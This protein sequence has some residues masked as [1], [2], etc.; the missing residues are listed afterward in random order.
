MSI[1]AEFKNRIND[2]INEEVYSHKVKRSELPKFMGVDYSSL[3]NAVEYGII[4]TPRII[5]KMADYFD[6]SIPYLLGKSN[7]EY[8]SKSKSNETFADRTQLLC[9]EKNVTP[10]FVC[11]ECNF[12]PGYLT[13]WIKNGYIP[14]WEFLD[15]LADYF[16]VSPDYLLGRTDD[17]N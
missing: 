13:R 11:K 4:P 10:G 7:D 8:F 14:S 1:S 9:K 2:L 6:V 12:Y 15:I 17:R 5:I 16:D 3:F